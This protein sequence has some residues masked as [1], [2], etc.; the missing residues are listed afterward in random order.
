MGWL[1][2]PYLDCPPSIQTQTIIFFGIRW[3]QSQLIQ[4]VGNLRR[5]GDIGPACLATQG[6]RYLQLETR[7]R[8][9]PG[10]TEIVSRGTNVQ[11]AD[12]GCTSDKH[13]KRTDVRLADCVERFILRAAKTEIVG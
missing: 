4:S 13:R 8:C 9:R 5:V 11:F 10:N 1:V 7:G 2:F 12:R 3:G 6:I